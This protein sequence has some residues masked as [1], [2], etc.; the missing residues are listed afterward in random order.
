MAYIEEYWINK[1]TRTKLAQIHTEQVGLFYKDAID[2]SIKNTR[3]YSA[4]IL[5]SN[6]TNLNKTKIIVEDNDTV[7]AIFKHKKDNL[8]IAALNFASYKKPGGMFLDGSKAQEECLCHESF[9]YNVLKEQQEYYKYNCDHKN[10]GLYTNRALYTPNILF[11]RDIIG[12]VEADIV[13]CAAPNLSAATKYCNITADENSEALYNRI[14]FVLSIAKQEKVDTLILGAYGCGV[15]GQDPYEVA[16]IFKYFLTA[17]ESP[18]YNVFS[19]VIFAV[20][21]GNNQNLEAFQKTFN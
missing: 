13:T 7:S 10:K 11:A 19:E 2:N 9:L 6:E 1:E 5:V 14:G 18:F 8:R 20:P 12:T 21:E 3:I 17:E 4:K 15:F 16:Y